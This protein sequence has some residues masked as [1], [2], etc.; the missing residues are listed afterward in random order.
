MKTV[1][2][3]CTGNSARSVLAEAILARAGSPDIRAV[4][5]GSRPAGQVNP[6]AVELLASLYYQTDTFRSKSWEELAAPGA[7]PMD[8]V[9]TVCDS[10]ANE[11]CPVWPGQPLTVHWGMPDPAAEQGP[12]TARRAAFEQTYTVLSHRIGRLV[13]LIRGSDDLRPLHEQIAAL[14]QSMPAGQ[15]AVPHE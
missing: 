3:L 15:D 5:A 13:D 11:S 10:A 8:L 1:A 4:S 12:D 2:F 9:I 6:F 7:G 14:G